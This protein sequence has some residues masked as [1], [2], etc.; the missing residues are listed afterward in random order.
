[1]LFKPTLEE[2][3]SILE[4]NRRLEGMAA[5]LAARRLTPSNAVEIEAATRACENH[6]AKH[7]DD[8]PDAYYG[9]NLRFHG[10]VAASSGNP[11]LLEMIKTHGRK[12]LAYYRVAYRHPG[13]IAH[14]AS[15]HR[16]LADL[17]AGRKA[18]EAEALMTQHV[19]FD[20]V[21]VMDLLAAQG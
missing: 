15:E 16:Q 4:V 14:S 3:L 2:F 10:A 1:M 6:A 8:G 12:L 9:L 11:Y 19:G 21:T 20:T 17:I 7:G 13:A 18:D 5:G